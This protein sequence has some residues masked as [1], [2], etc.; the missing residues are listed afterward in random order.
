M[1]K[2]RRSLGTFGEAGF[3]SW[4]GERLHFKLAPR[5]APG[6]LR[7][8]VGT[9]RI[10]SGAPKRVAPDTLRLTVVIAP[11]LEDFQASRINKGQSACLM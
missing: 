11:Q 2:S 1:N 10:A 5:L 6:L 3:H 9:E 8:L 4:C 7:I